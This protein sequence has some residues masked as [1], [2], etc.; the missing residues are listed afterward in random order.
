MVRHAPP[1]HA[2]VDLLG[3][4]A[5]DLE[6]IARTFRQIVSV[7]AADGM[8][9][10]A[11]SVVVDEIRKTAGYAGA[12]VLVSAELARARCKVQVDIGFG[13]AV[14]PGPVHA[15]YPVL[16]ADFAPPS[17]VFGM[18]WGNGLGNE[19]G[20][21]CGM[22]GLGRIGGASTVQRHRRWQPQ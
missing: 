21:D 17:R 19:S 3:F 6:S 5:S 14:T 1:A 8:V 20:N 13:D 11:A 10:D 15:T 2:D 12:R 9:F 22:L 16:L 4:G 7:S 18:G